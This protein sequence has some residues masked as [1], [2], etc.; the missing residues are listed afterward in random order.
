MTTLLTE[1]QQDLAAGYVLGDL[2][3]EEVLQFELQMQKNAALRT[4][5]NALQTALALSSQALPMVQP[6]ARLR[7]QILATESSLGLSP[8]SN[9]KSSLWQ[10][11]DVTWS[12][13][14]AGLGI[15]TTIILGAYS[16]QLRQSLSVALQKD[17]TDS[18]ASI[19]QR[20][21]SR[22]VA[23][24]GERNNAAGTLLFT[25]GKWKEVVVSLGN[26][27]PLPPDQ[28]YRMWLTLSDGNVLPCG[29]F[30]TDVQGSV[31]IKLNPPQ[32][33]SKANKAVGIFVT[34]APV[35]APLAPEGIRIMTGKI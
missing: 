34:T 3:L 28:V 16:I 30:N 7:A 4:E 1:Q 23:L 14:I 21:N 9:S 11:A 33:P 19:L 15:F 22:L 13:L 18:T 2:S 8:E 24:K 12:Q 26:L 17:K 10:R 6:P 31:F 35:S 5:V 25:P 29:S 32:S 27:P 20:P